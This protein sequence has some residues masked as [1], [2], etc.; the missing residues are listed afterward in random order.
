[1]PT[2]RTF[3]RA[4]PFGLFVVLTVAPASGLPGAPAAQQSPQPRPVT[5]VE[6]ELKCVDDSTLKLKILDERLDVVTKYG[7]LQVPV[8]DIRR[9]DFATRTPPD[10]A[11]KVN[12]LIAALNHP[13]FDTREKATAE[14]RSYKE[15]AYL[16]LLKA[17]KHPDAEISRRAEETVR[18]LQQKLPPGQLE[19]RES[20]VIYTD[21]SKFTGKLIAP[22][23]R[24]LTSQFGEQALRLSDIRALRTGPGVT[25]EVGPAVAAPANLMTYQ[26]QYGK[27]LLFTVIGPQPGGAAQGVWG[28]DVYTLD[29][30]LAVAA[31]HAGL[32]QP[33][34]AA[35]VRV[36]V[37]A[38]PIQFVGS[39]RNGVGSAPYGNYPSGAYEFI[40][41]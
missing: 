16:P 12:A 10:V 31:L 34:Q 36:R 1:M 4:V 24:V 26:N 5:G 9:I 41:K 14:L 27:E 22:T 3:V 33:G 35:V 18:Y 13:D 7:S 23:L 2:I 39:F 8:A 32:V 6:V 29:S 15:R 25:E 19:P 30:N 38:S 11:E 20:D 21:D 28:T 37:I 40:R 17:I